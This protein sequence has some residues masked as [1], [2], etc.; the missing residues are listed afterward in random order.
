MRFGS[1]SGRVRRNAT[2]AAMSPPDRRT[3][4]CCPSRRRRRTC[5]LTGRHRVCRNRA[6]PCR[7]TGSRSARKRHESLVCCPGA[8][9]E[10]DRANR[11]VA[12]GQIEPVTESHVAVG[13]EAGARSCCRR[14]R[15]RRAHRPARA[16]QDREKHDQSFEPMHSE[17]LNRA[18]AFGCAG[19][20][21]MRKPVLRRGRTIWLGRTKPAARYPILR[22]HHETE[23][24]IVGGGMTGAMIAES[25]TRAGRSRRGRRGGSHR[26]RQHRGEHRASP[27]GARLRSQGAERAIRTSRR[28]AHLDAQPGC[29]RAISSTTIERLKITCDLSK[30]DSLY[31]TLDADARAKLQRELQRRHKAGLAGSVARP[32]GAAA[33]QRHSRR[34]RDPHQRQR[35]IE[36]AASLRRTD[37]RRRHDAMPTIFERST[38]NRIRQ[39]GDG[40]RLVFSR[41]ARSTRC[42]S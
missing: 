29:R 41:R 39:L 35:A 21:T 23:V 1:I 16:A 36:S 19:T 5:P 22:G 7:G 24:A 2:P 10:H 32:I 27:S 14:R 18:V 3:P 12:L 38:I 20:I 8:V 33:R 31:Y 6:S 28:E 9:S 37:R 4:E 15:G 40:V 34:R 26:A 17:P 13:E 30:R 25:F 42:R 11:A